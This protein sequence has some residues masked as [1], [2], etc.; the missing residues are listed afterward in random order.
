MACDLAE[1][2]G[3]ALDVVVLLFLQ[4]KDFPYVEALVIMLVAT[5]STCFRAEILFFQP[6]VGEILQGYL[7]KREILQNL[8]IL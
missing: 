2:L 8:E 1:L 3:S 6:N 4:S 7:L 5:I